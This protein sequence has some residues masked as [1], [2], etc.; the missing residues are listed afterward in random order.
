[1]ET[2]VSSLS[3]MNYEWPRCFLSKHEKIRGEIK[4]D[5]RMLYLCSTV[6]GVG[7]GGVGNFSFCVF[8]FQCFH[9]PPTPSVTAGAEKETKPSKH[10]CVWCN[11]AA[12]LRSLLL[13]SFLNWINEMLS[14]QWS[15]FVAF[16]RTSPITSPSSPPLSSSLIDPTL[17]LLTGSWHA[18]MW[19]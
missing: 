18:V 1:M 14:Q 7:L 4:S 16:C 9:T 17:W 10:L 5:G 2:F 12:F 15:L 19:D 8:V 3:F 11:L 13:V 6:W